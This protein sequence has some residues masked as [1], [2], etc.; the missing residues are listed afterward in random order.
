QAVRPKNAQRASLISKIASNSDARFRHGRSPLAPV[1]ALDRTRY[2]FGLRERPPHPI[3]LFS[4]PISAIKLNRD[5]A[6]LFA[7]SFAGRGLG[8]SR[9]VYISPRKSPTL[10]LNFGDILETGVACPGTSW[11]ACPRATARKRPAR[12]SGTCSRS[13]VRGWWRS[14][15]RSSRTGRDEI[16]L[17]DVDGCSPRPFPRAT[18]LAQEPMFYIGGV[19]VADRDPRARQ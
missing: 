16:V 13:N 15:W 8:S 4:N 18:T 1:S 2:L 7:V 11:R 14:G 19:P 3:Y 12:A 5:S 6:R 17:L 10:D 9:L